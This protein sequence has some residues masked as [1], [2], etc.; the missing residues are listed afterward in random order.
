MRFRYDRDVQV[1]LIIREIIKLGIN[2][3]IVI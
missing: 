3:G 1:L 2:N